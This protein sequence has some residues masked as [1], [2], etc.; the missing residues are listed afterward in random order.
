VCLGITTA[1]LLHV[2]L[3]IIYT[4]FYDTFY[5]LVEVLPA[6]LAVRNPA[7][8]GNNVPPFVGALTPGSFFHN[9]V[10]QNIWVHRTSNHQ[11]LHVQK[12]L[13]TC[14]C[15]VARY[16]MHDV[17]KLIQPADWHWLKR[18]QAITVLYWLYIYMCTAQPQAVNY[19][20]PQTQTVSAALAGTGPG[21]FNHLHFS[22]CFVRVHHVSVVQTSG[23][24][25][26]HPIVAE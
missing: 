11:S 3:C 22:I 1:S 16:S 15:T 13:L 8:L 18:S 17:P 9:P 19:A 14:K 2:S 5:P 21:K 20:Q 26:C 10:Q 23:V 24:R 4:G 12:L 25:V 6:Q 7:E